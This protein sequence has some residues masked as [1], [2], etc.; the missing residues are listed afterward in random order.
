[1]QHDLDGHY[2]IGSEFAN[3]VLMYDGGDVNLGKTNRVADSVLLLGPHAIL[4]NEVVRRLTAAFSSLRV[5][6][7]ASKPK[8]WQIVP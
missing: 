7:A 2:Y 6:Y 3:S 4:E 5:A 8:P 1:M